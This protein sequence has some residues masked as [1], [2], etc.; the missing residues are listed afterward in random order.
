[1][2]I[3]CTDDPAI[4]LLAGQALLSLLWRG[5][6]DPLD[7]ATRDLSLT[8][9][10]GI[11]EAAAA[12]AVTG[13]SSQLY[14]SGGVVRIDDEIIIYSATAGGLTLSQRGAFGT[15]AAAH[16]ALAA[17]EYL[18]PDYEFNAWMT[19][20][21]V[22]RVYEKA[23]KAA[24]MLEEFCSSTGLKFWQGE[25]LLIHVKLMA[26]P[27]YETDP[28]EWTEAVNII[29][30]SQLWDDGEPERITRA[31]IYYAPLNNEPGKDSKNYGG[32]IV[33]I[34]A[35]NETANAYG[36][37]KSIQIWAPWL[38]DQPSALA[39][40]GRY[41]IRYSP[42]AGTLTLRVADKD[43]GI[44]LGDFIRVTSSEIL[45]ETGQPRSQVLFEVLKRTPKSDGSW[46]FLLIDTRIDYQ[47]GLISA[48]DQVDWDAATADEIAVYGFIGDADNLLDGE[49]G[50][51]I[52]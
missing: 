2:E 32:R 14:D 29:E 22:K 23:V 24:E 33:D 9:S 10:A 8:L 6:M 15:T 25:D 20:L 16:D 27:L 12:A 38:M 31:S 42:G 44:M 30:G 21:R 49:D 5:G 36:E 39:V 41:L 4:G 11:D 43:S 40:V 48:A 51:Y 28:E 19:G 37:S 34:M 7:V 46:E 50:Y 45:D 17:I 26:P 18:E 1:V 3:F 47:T 35:D 13:D 52:S